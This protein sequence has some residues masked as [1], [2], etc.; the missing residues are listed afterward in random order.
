MASR[1]IRYDANLP[2]NLTYPH[3]RKSFYWRNPITG[4]EITLGQIT[5]RDAISQA[6]QANNYIES[7][8]QP[9]ALLDSQE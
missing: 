5:R 4:E 9:V 6:I 7:N 2:R 8:F 1:P 3:A